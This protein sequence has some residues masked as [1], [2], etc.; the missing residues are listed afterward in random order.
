MN[1]RRWIAALSVALALY[2]GTASAQPIG[3]DGRQIRGALSGPLQMG[4]DRTDSTARATTMNSDGTLSTKE[5]SPAR[6]AN[7][8]FQDIINN[9]GVSALAIGA[10]DSSAVL[11]THD[12]RLGMLLIKAAVAG[13]GTVDT[14]VAVRIAVQLRTHLGGVD[15]SMSAFPIYLYGNSPLGAAG[16]A[17]V[18]T[19]VQGHIYNATSLTG[20]SA[21]P[22]AWTAWSGEQTILIHAKRNAHGSSI[23]INGHTHYYP[24]GI[25]IPLSSIFGR[26]IYSPYTSVR[27]RVMSAH[28]GAATFSTATVFVAAHLVG[29]PL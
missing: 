19:T 4:V 29:T 20:L 16:T 17:H 14:T 8:T 7:L 26:D 25:A 15:D 18:D 12:M 21:T 6:D 5:A 9:F 23:A 1:C 2:A 11:D 24:N 28:K 13:T 10:A 27:I 3:T 22:T